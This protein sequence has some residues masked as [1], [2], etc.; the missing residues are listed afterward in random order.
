MPASK[1]PEIGPTKY[2]YRFSRYPEAKAGPRLLAGLKLAPVRGPKNKTR[3]NKVVPTKRAWF[4][5]LLIFVEA[6]NNE[7]ARIKVPIT[8]ISIPRIGFIP[9]ASFDEPRLA[10]ASIRLKRI[11]KVNPASRPPTIS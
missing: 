7:E 1:A 3:M 11:L 8:S 6:I 10:F 4:L 2:T 5:A 9:L